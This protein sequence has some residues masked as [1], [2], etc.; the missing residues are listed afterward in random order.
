[1]ARLILHVDLDA[2]FASVEELDDPSLVGHPLV[3]GADPRNGQ[4]R[5][6][7]TTCNYAAR[8]FG[9]RSAMPISQAWRLCP[10]ANFVRGHY[11]RYQEKSHEVFAILE[12]VGGPFEPASIDEAY[13]DIT[14]TVDHDFDQAIDL[15]KRLQE[16]IQRAT[17]LSASIGVASNKMMAKIA[18]DHD[19]PHG[20]TTVNPGHEAAFLASLPARKIPGVGPKSAERLAEMGLVTCADVA[21]TSPEELR[22]AF[23]T[24]GPDLWQRAH[25]RHESPVDASWERKSMG[26]ERTFSEDQTDPEVWRA[27]LTDMADDLAKGLRKERFAA[28]TITLKVRM[29]G[30]ETYTRGVS[31]TIPTDRAPLILTTALGLLRENPP[32]RAVRLLGIRL[33]NLTRAVARQVPLSE[34]DALE[35]GEAPPWQPDQKRLDNW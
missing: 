23:G 14:A 6:V 3:V 21:E 34:W 17:G 16:Q 31:L 22:R 20:I 10:Q 35:L 9:I 8:E 25:G 4:G 2:F 27:R 13:L 5:G 18:S 28:K 26:E 32:A 15:A 29:T 11:K 12:A 7:V 30:F 19:K 24:W 33:S 1:M